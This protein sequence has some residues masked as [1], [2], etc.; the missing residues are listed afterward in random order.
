MNR[1][2]STFLSTLDR[3]I[4]G[5]ML[6]TFFFMVLIFSMI[7]IV[8]DISDKLDNFLEHKMPFKTI[9]L[10]YYLPFIPN[11]NGLLIPLYALIAVIFFTSRMAASCELISIIGSGVS[12]NRMM[13]P[14]MIGAAII[15]SIYLL[16]NHFIIPLGNQKR[17]AFENK[18]FWGGNTI[19][20]S[21]DLHIFIKPD[22]KIYMKRYTAADSS[23]IEFS[24]E[25]FDSTGNLISRLNA[26]R[27]EWQPFRR[28]WKLLNY[29]VRTLKGME[30]TY[31][32]SGND[33]IIAWLPQYLKPTSIERRDN[34]NQTMTTPQLLKFINEE[35]AR[36]AGGYSYYE[37]EL[38]RRTSD[39][40][41]VFILTIIGAAL[42]GRRVRGGMGLHLA[43]GAIIGGLFIFFT[44]FASTISINT[45]IPAS[46]SV[47]IPSLIFGIL[48]VYLY[49]TA[50]K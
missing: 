21:D 1:I 12:Y 7:G 6:S 5:K 29:H 30:E 8:V 47:W 19:S 22:T 34:L 27:A 9:L 20:K 14:Y 40:F 37:V 38:H 41:T 24:L 13:R 4:L 18:Y 42:A 43:L 2:L 10:D 28:D 46:I 44:K 32:S 35:R 39:P 25:T 50:Q 49:K 48:A 36:G 45:S 15:A 17:C 11:L 23:A 26:A 31:K 3:Y 16:G 33:T